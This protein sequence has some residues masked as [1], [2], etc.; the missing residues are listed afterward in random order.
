[1]RTPLAL[2]RATSE[3]ALLGNQPTLRIYKDALRRILN[4]T[5]KTTA[6]LESL[7]RLA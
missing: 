1:L 6:L 3:V 5:E 2:I 7:L 4:E